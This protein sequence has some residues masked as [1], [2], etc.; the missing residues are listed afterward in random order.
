MYIPVLYH[1]HHHNMHN[2]RGELVKLKSDPLA[3]YH[4]IILMVYA[5]ED[6]PVST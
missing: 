2:D 4:R 5:R 1:Q 6:D 3:I